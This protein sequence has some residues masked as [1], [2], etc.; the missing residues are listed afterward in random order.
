MKVDEFPSYRKYVGVDVWFK[1]ISDRKFIEVKKIGDKYII[2]QV[3]AFQY[4]EMIFIQDMLKKSENRWE[5]ASAELIE[6][7]ITQ[8]N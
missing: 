1:I 3:E 7:L 2:H 4:P 6:E 8:A 5:N